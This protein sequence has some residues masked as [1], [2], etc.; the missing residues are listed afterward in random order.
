MIEALDVHDIYGHAFHCT[1]KHG[2]EKIVFNFTTHIEFRILICSDIFHGLMEIKNIKSAGHDLEV[3]LSHWK[4]NNGPKG[5]ML[6]QMK[7]ALTSCKFKS[8]LYQIIEPYRKEVTQ[9]Y[10]MDM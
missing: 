5:A 6:N 9:K 7:A 10:V 1:D 4:N 8:F 3:S 2:E